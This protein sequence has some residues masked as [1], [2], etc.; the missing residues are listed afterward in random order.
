M[1]TITRLTS[2]TNQ[3]YINLVLVALFGLFSFSNSY[4]QYAKDGNL[5]VTASNTV[6]N[7]YS[8]VTANVAAGATTI[9]VNDVLGDLGGLTAGDLILI[10][11]AQGA[12]IDTSDSVAF[13]AVTNLNGAGNYEY[14]YVESVSGND[15]NVCPLSL[16]YFVGGYTQVVKVPQYDTLIINAGTSITATAWQDS[17]IYRIG[18]IVAIN[19]VTII[20]NGTID[21]SEIGFRGGIIDNDTS[22]TGTSLITTYVSSSTSEGA[23]KGESIAGFGPEYDALG[24]RYSRGAPANGGGGG[25]GH[26]AGGGGGANGNNGNVWFNGAGVMCATCTGSAAW[27][28]DP[29]Y[30]AN[31]MARTNS[32]GGGRGGYTF[33]FNDQDAL[34]RAPGSSEWTG[35]YRDPVGG[36][37]G[38]PMNADPLQS[39]FFGGGGG[40]GDGNNNANNDGGDGGG[41]ILLDAGNVSGIGSF[42]ANGQIAL[43]TI[44]GHNDAPGGGGA[45]GTIII[46]SPSISNT[47]TLSA[48]GGDGG[49]QLITNDE[50]EGPG[51]GG[52]GGFI[53]I[54]NGSPTTSVIGGLN[55]TTTSDAVTEFPANGATIGATGQSI[56]FVG[57]IVTSCIIATNDDFTSPPINGAT[58]GTTASVFPNDT[59]NGIAFANTDVIPSIINN[60]GLTGLTINSAGQFIVPAGTPARTYIIEYQICETA[61]PT[62]CDTA[63]VYITVVPDSDGDGIDDIT[64]LD[65]DNDGILDTDETGATTS[66]QPNC[67]THTVLN[68]NNAFSE[69]PGG[70]GN[71]STFLQGE[72]FRFPAVATVGTVTVDALVTIVS[73]F[74][75]SIPIL[76]DNT[77]DINSFKPQTQFSLPNVGDIA[78]TEY[79]FDFVDAAD[80]SP[81]VLPEFFVNFN[82][83][84][85]NA[86][87]GEQNWS[88]FP[89]GFTVNN[90]TEL[91]INPSDPWII[92]TSGT[93]EYTGAGNGNSEVNYSTSHVNSSNYTI[94]LGMVARTAGASASGRQHNVEFNCISNFIDP[95]TSNLDTDGDGT[96]D[97]LDTDS[98]NDG[99]ADADE[100]YGA[101]GTDTNGDG[102]YG[103]VIGAG[104]V[105]PDGTV[106][107]A[108]YPGTNSNVITATQVTINSVPSNQSENTGDPATF[109]VVA[110]AI[111]TSVFASGVPDYTIPPATDVSATLSYQWQENG[112]NLSD[113]GVYSGTTT[114]TLTISDVAGLDGNTYNVIVFRN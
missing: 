56:S 69:E 23:E 72:T 1:K 113:G 38:R 3:S 21:V 86:N 17:G 40:A 27:S 104:Q 109:S 94:R 108:G 82:D 87:Y 112:T 84:D 105:N 24:G 16:S 96:P 83:V 95:Q 52:S 103:G 13:G 89:T 70:D 12:I 62:N 67:G 2:L 41:I 37:G 61:Q 97:Y 85:G 42:L 36:L 19:A 111:S 48:N 106:I 98:D 50:S 66:A 20:N 107:G 64:D 60:D 34:T 6:V 93:T 5:I 102:T 77:V 26:N 32:S 49:D 68:F 25:N 92:G 39:I 59:L 114:A 29:D 44:S 31:A 35:D 110:T 4:A 7:S 10:Y 55:G 100:A 78:Y 75:T 8:A 73:L 51:G 63:L 101:A 11:Q 91:T 46:E 80:D 22:A 33:G 65:D 71:L 74:N 76:D 43:N 30:I 18:G 57:D 58:G 47:L 28:L 53:A 79:R 54:T 99:C 90:L 88:Q 15:I 14:A 9:S 81:V 45:G